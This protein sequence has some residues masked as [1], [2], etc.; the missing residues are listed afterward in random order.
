MPYPRRQ[1]SAEK[2]PQ[3]LKKD[4]K[5]QEV[6]ISPIVPQKPQATFH[7]TSKQPMLKE[8]DEEPK[9]RR[10]HRKAQ[11]T[12]NK[13]HQQRTEKQNAER[14]QK[15]AE[16]PDFAPGIELVENVMFCFK[17]WYYLHV[18]SNAILLNLHI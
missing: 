1:Q 11:P 10:S 6:M 12:D 15:N 8:N 16:E 13:S 2:F 18:L 4:A 5:P 7:D 14:E 3:Q 17:Y 9:G